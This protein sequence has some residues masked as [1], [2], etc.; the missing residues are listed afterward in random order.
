MWAEALEGASRW[1]RVEDT[2]QVEL[3]T[4]Q[5]TDKLITYPV[6][7]RPLPARIRGAAHA[8]AFFDGGAAQKLGTGGFVVYNGE[9]KCVTAQARFYGDELPT[10]NKAEAKALEEL[11]G[12]LAENQGE[13]GEAPAVVVYGD[14][15]LVVNFCNR[16]ARP[17]VGELYASVQEIMR[18]RRCIGTP[19]FFRHVP[20]EL[21]AVADW[22]ANAARQH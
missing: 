12:W 11:M 7:S 14:S 6:T 5:H 8:V 21:N 19:V 22:L 13:W 15:Q 2:E 9:G 18:H 10:N 16:R 17:S 20:R 1:V 4:F 3:P